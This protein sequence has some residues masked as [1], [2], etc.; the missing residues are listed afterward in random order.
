MREKILLLVDDQA[1]ARNAIRSLIHTIDD[2]LFIIPATSL[3]EATRLIQEGITPALTLLDL[4]MPN[5]RHPVN[6][7]ETLRIFRR[8]CPT[9]PVLA[10]LDHEVPDID[11]ACKQEGILGL[12]HK[13]AETRVVAQI[14]CNAVVKAGIPLTKGKKNND[15]S[16]STPPPTINAA[17]FIPYDDGRDAVNHNTMSIPP[18]NP[19][20][21]ERLIDF[22]M[23][24]REYRDG[25]H[26]GF[27]VRQRTVLQLV[28]KGF[29]NKAICRALDMAEGTVKIHVSSI[30]RLLRVSSRSQVA[31]AAIQYGIVI[32]GINEK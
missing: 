24:S 22:N 27:T 2:S 12:I 5:S 25:R 30:L 10:M 4:Q 17:V 3:E 15:D 32:K 9:M 31:M 21:Q 1:N 19:D 13:D 14:F 23:P 18:I 20:T 16:G 11:S 29:S 28:A 6:G 7:I 26:L 8:H